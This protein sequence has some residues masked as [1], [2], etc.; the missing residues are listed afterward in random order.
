MSCRATTTLF[1]AALLL[2][3]ATGQVVLRMGLHAIARISAD[4]RISAD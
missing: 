3:A 1:V 2:V 4:S